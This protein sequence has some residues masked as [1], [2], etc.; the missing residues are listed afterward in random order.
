MNDQK[1][2]SSDAWPFIDYKQNKQYTHFKFSFE[3]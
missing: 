2:A 1:A 3:Y